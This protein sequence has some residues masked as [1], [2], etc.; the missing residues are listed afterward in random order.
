MRRH[1][2]KE[3]RE[4]WCARRGR[5]IGFADFISRTKVYAKTSP[6]NLTNHKALWALYKNTWDGIAGMCL[7]KR[8][9]GSATLAV[10]PSSSASSSSSS[11]PACGS[12]DGGAVATKVDGGAAA[13]AADEEEEEEDNDEEEEEEEDDDDA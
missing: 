12:G 9:S 4:R 10:L 6:T 7:F 11:E 1:A 5:I 2:L 13:A 8:G 3:G